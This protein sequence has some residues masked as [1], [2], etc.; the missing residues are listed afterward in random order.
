MSKISGASSFKNVSVSDKLQVGIQRV[1]PTAGSTV[2]ATG[3]FLILEPAGTLAT[4]TLKFP[5]GATGQVFRF[6]SSQDVTA[7]TVTNG[8]IAGGSPSALVANV[9]KSY[10]F[11][12]GKWWVM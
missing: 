1:V 8:T 10:V 12:G 6:V 4:L 3:P 2:T 9:S 5:T 7:L 11:Y